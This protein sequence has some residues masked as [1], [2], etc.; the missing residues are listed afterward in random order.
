[1][2]FHRLVFASIFIVCSLTRFANGATL[3]RDEVEAL[4]SIGRTLV[5]TDWN[6][7]DIDPCSGARGWIDPPSSSYANN[8]TCDC[9]FNNSNTCHVTH[10]LLKTQ[11]LSGTLP[12][13]L[14]S[15]PF[16]QEIDLTRNYLSGNIPPQWGSASRLV[17]ISLLG[18][19][20]TGEIPEELA[21][22]SNLTSLVLEVNGLWGNLPRAL[23]NLSK[24][25]RLHLSSNNFTGGIPDAYARLTSLKEFRISDNN[26]TGRIPEFMF[27]SWR[28][29]TLIYMEG[30][31]LSGPI[32]SINTTLENLK[33]IIISDLNGAEAAF[34]RLDADLPSLD[35]V[36][37]RSCNLIEEIPAFLG[38][39]TT[40]KILDLS[41]N[42][43]SG[44]IPD[45]SGLN[46]DTLYLNGNNF[47]GA[48]PRWILQTRE[49]MD[50][51]YNNFTSTGGVTD[52][53]SPTLNLF[54]SIPR[55]NNSG[56]VP[57]LSNQINCTE[58]LHSVYI[59]CGG[60][61]KSI[62]GTNYEG[63]VGQAG[64]S[65][66]LRSDSNW[67]LSST[68]V[69]LNDDRNND[70]L[71]IGNADGELHENA[72]LSPSSLTYYAFC[73]ANAS[74][75]VN[76]HFAEIQ[77][78]NQNYSSLGRRVFD[79]YIQGQRV[80]KDFNIEEAAGGAGIQVVRPF[81]V[82]VT[83]GT[84]EI[85][86]RWAGKGTTS[87]PGRGVYGPLISAISIFDPAYTPAMP[88]AESD[89]GGIAVA[90]VV[91]IV[92]GGVFAA[93]LLVGILW[94]KGCLRRER[95]LEQGILTDK[96]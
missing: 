47:T 29:L 27:R 86:L 52:C 42:R 9:S 11:N 56:I 39:F 67:A 6:F 53:G 81:A 22:L 41:F 89:G 60:R 90:A 37:L 77:F 23:G 87:I 49:E 82:N 5:K 58:P 62:N 93:L 59:N 48:V 88:R 13:N 71:T 91:G 45:L 73:L 75:T 83:D 7:D 61:P 78:T 55:T 32:P 51:S 8:V 72:R 33:Y 54:S 4:R 10:I 24:L 21:N 64:P 3:G 79:V 25:E 17:N 26:F 57:C 43:L 18:N 35:R 14:D 34:P 2:L 15:L 92:A 46:L 65:T 16:L 1:M 40:I 50:V 69:F 94:W 76:L 19:R 36:M 30:S 68:G 96:K 31:G 12:T 44:E 95:T 66:F 70:I 20:L 84:L 38:R 85:H 28:N 63:D 74:Y 80:L